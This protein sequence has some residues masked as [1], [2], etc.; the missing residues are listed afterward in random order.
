M[1][2]LRFPKEEI[3]HYRDKYSY[4]LNDDKIRKKT[5][6]AVKRGFLLKQE[7]LDICYW[8]T[9]RSQSKC[10]K[11]E[12]DFI[13]DI[14]KVSLYTDNEK[15]KIEI[16]TLLFGVKWP[17]ASTILHFCFPE[18]YPILDYRALWSLSVDSPPSVYNF[19]FWWDYVMI[20]R[21]VSE[22]LGITIRELDKALWQYSKE[23][24][25]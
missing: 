22:E 15:L 6:I 12:D 24:Q 18:Q 10:S 20:C 16:L 13:I 21:E 17:T 8:K 14:T 2:K 7:L 5:Q 11:N 1:F 9:P 3:I 23:N 25:I 19:Y 4:P